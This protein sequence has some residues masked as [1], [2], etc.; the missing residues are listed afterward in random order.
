M[1]GAWYGRNAWLTGNPLY[2]LQV[3]LLGRVWLAG[4]YGPEVMTLSQYYIAP[5]DWRALGDILLAVF[6]PRQLPLWAA[7]TAGAWSLGRGRTGRD[8][9]VWACSALAIANVATYWGV[10]PYRSQ[11]RF[12]LQACG[13]LVVPL[14]R[15]FDRA[16][17]LRV[18]AAVLLAVHLCT[19]QSWP[20]GPAERDPPWDLTSRVPSVVAPLLSLPYMTKVSRGELVAPDDITWSLAILGL[21][22]LA[23][24]GAWLWSRPGW[25]ARVRALAGTIALG[26]AAIALGSPF[27]ADPRSSF[28]PVFPD[29]YRGWLQLEALAGPAGAR[30]AYAGT[31]LPYY[32]LGVGLRNEVRYVNVD[33]HRGWLMHDYHRRARARGESGWPNP[34]PGWDRQHPSYDAWLANLRAERIDLLVVASR[35]RFPGELPDADP[36]GFPIERRWAEA[37]PESFAPLYGVAERDA[38]FRIYRVRPRTDSREASNVP[39]RATGIRGGQGSLTEPTSPFLLLPGGQ[40]MMIDRQLL[41]SVREQPSM[42]VMRAYEEVVDFIASGVTPESIV[43]FRPSEATRRRVTDLVAREKTSG[44]TAD[45]TAELNYYLQLEHIMCLAIARARRHLSDE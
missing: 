21:G 43:A 19:A 36:E 11:Q 35:G 25:R 27:Q 12:M 7:A 39:P 16:R 8:G 41:Q 40:A 29:Y 22:A 1:V 18:L 15:L 33:A 34:W 13:L 23:L 45:E 32:L 5:G 42:S 6:D 30:I 24:A 31:N 10:V 26:A 17:F 9:F 2:P 14:A 4:W 44:L 20:F 3:R 38:K 37:H 28:Y